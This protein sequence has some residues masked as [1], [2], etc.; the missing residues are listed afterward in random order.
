MKAKKAVFIEGVIIENCLF[1][2]RQQ[3]FCIHRVKFGDDK[4]AI[5]RAASGLCFEPGSIIVRNESEW[6]YNHVKVR[7]LGF[8]YLEEKESIRRFHEYY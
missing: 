6:F 4:F 7:L 5:V 8:E 3:S 2:E 1:G